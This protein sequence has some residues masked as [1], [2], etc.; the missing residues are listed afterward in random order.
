MVPDGI[1]LDID[2]NIYIAAVAQSAIVR[3]NTDGS[4]D[5]LADDPDRELLDFTSSVAFGTTEGMET[6]L[7]AVNLALGPPGANGP[8]LLT[9]DVGVAGLPLP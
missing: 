3:V 9:L 2:G 4:F 5:I 7:Y 1:A 8:A 6:T